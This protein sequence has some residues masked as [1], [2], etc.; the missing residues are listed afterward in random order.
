[1]LSAVVV[2]PSFKT[3][4]R[5]LVDGIRCHMFNTKEHGGNEN[6]TSAINKVSRGQRIR[7]DKRVCERDSKM[8]KKAREEQ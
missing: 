2:S 5:F 1:M 4:R 7:R 6:E 8:G 3:C